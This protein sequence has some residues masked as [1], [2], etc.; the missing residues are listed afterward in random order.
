MEKLAIGP[1]YPK[2]MIDIDMK[3]SEIVREI[4]SFKKCSLSEI[5]VCVLER[6]R[7]D[8]LIEELRVCGVKVCLISDGDVAGVIH[9]AEPEK[10]GIDLYLGQGGAPEG[11]LAAAA[12]KCLGGEFQGRLIFKT[13]DEKNR[14]KKVGLENLKKKYSLE[15]LVKDDVIFSATGVTNGSLVSGICIRKNSIETETLLMR[16]KTGSIRYLKYKKITS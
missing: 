16:S 13:E 10:T 8:N 5:K 11:V 4:S 15:D 12:L 7:H 14:A 6:P 3:P 2:N 1:G 9:C